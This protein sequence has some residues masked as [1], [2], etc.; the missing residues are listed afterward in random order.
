MECPNCHRDNLRDSN[1]C[2]NCGNPFVQIPSPN[3]PI[4]QVTIGRDRTKSI[5]FAGAII[6]IWSSIIVGVIISSLDTFRTSTNPTDHV[7]SGALAAIAL[8]F[9]VIITIIFFRG[10]IRN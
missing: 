10:M 7:V 3:A 5:F 9:L 6:A 2:S 1:F 4:T 8:T